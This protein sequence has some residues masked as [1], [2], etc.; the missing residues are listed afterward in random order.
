MAQND[1]LQRILNLK[2]Q[3]ID[4]V[5]P[6][7]EGNTFV[8]PS[9]ISEE[10]LR[11][12]EEKPKG[13]LQT[14][15]YIYTS[16]R[17]SASFNQNELNS[18][19]IKR[20]V[21][22]MPEVLENR[23]IEWKIIE[24]TGCTSPQMGKT[25]FHGFVLEYRPEITE[26]RREQEIQNL[27]AFLQNPSAGYRMSNDPGVSSVNQQ[28]LLNDEE[29]TNKDATDEKSN[30]KADS[31][32][33]YP[34]GNFALYEYLKKN[35]PTGGKMAL[36]RDDEWVAFEMTVDENGK[37]G[38]LTFEDG[39]KDY[40]KEAVISVIEGMPDW[41]PAVKNGQPVSS[42]VDLELRMSFSPIVRGMYNRDGKKPDFNQAEIQAAQAKEEMPDEEAQKRM[43]AAE[44]SAVYR[45]MDAVISKE[46]VAVVMDVTSSMSVHL[47]SM[48]WWVANSP[49]SL[50][51][52]YYTFFN[53]G[54]NMEDR[55]KKT[56]K[57]GGIYHGE[58]LRDLP[59]TLMEA[60][61]SGNGGDLVENDFEALL[62]AQSQGSNADALLLIVDNFSDVRDEKL[63][64]QITM[65]THVLISGDVTVVRECYLNLAKATGGSILVNGNQIN[66]ENVRSTGRITIAESTYEFDGRAFKLL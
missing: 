2:V 62:A 24:Q 64:S 66:L 9:S 16:Y 34:E 6:I 4:K 18:K 47:A 43:N 31:E 32:A 56:G 48:N 19:R 33:N 44:N 12:G 41:T 65:K 38:E 59:A 51:I 22:L 10:T 36:N 63:L 3:Q 11:N 27:E 1:G 58:K 26:K 30:A 29:N 25:F 13:E 53:D 46:K 21:D 28:L 52:V 55:K 60:M 50:N 39:I 42:D 20:L 57:T 40:L 23:Y 15:Y 49:D 8:L 37:I 35:I 14:V 7:K 5:Q 45:A 17:Q 61:R 54:N